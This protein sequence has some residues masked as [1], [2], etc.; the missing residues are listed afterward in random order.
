[1][2]TSPGYP[3]AQHIA[4]HGY[5]VKKKGS[6]GFSDDIRSGF[7]HLFKMEPR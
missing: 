2:T 5:S 3:A 6:S 4:F 7:D 1:M